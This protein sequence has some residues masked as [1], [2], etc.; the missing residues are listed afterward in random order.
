MGAQDIFFLGKGGGGGGRLEPNLPLF[1]PIGNAQ[2]L[3]EI[4]PVFTYFPK[5]MPVHVFTYFARKRKLD[6]MYVNKNRS[7]DHCTVTT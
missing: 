4:M 7:N 5:I 6:L 2:N 3:P 1:L